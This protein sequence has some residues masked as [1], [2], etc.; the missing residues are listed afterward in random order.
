M[1]LHSDPNHPYCRYCGELTYHEYDPFF[2]AWVCQNCFGGMIR[3]D[4]KDP[5]SI[6]RAEV[7]GLA[8]RVA[9]DG[10]SPAVKEKMK[11]IAERLKALAERL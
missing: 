2:H 9:K 10:Y 11:E 5:F 7:N 4:K 8:V 3:A 6:I 1:S